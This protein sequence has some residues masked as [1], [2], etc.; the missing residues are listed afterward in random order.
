MEQIKVTLCP[1]C[2][3]CPSVEITDRGVTIGEDDNTVTLTHE[4][5]FD[6]GARDRHQ[7]GWTDGLDKLAALFA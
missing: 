2:S 3:G 6:E 5:F 1:A 4:Q 7:A